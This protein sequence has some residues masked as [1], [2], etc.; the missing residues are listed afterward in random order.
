MRILL[1]GL[2]LLVTVA[3][4]AQ[5]T[6]EYTV[7][8]KIIGVEDGLSSRE[9]FCGLMDD[10]G[11]LWLGTR[12][13]LNRYDGK[14]FKVFNKQN[15][16][17][18]NKVINVAKTGKNNLLISYGDDGFDRKVCYFEVF[19]TKTF[20]TKQL[21]EIIPNMPFSV[22]DIIWITNGGTDDVNVLVARPY[23][24]YQLTSKGLRIRFDLTKW[25]ENKVSRDTGTNP[26]YKRTGY[27]SV[28]RNGYAALGLTSDPIYFVTPENIF[29]T[30]A[31]AMM[32]YIN[33]KNDFTY[34]FNGEFHQLSPDGTDRKIARYLPE[35]TI[36][37]THLVGL[38]YPEHRDYA[39]LNTVDS[40]LMLWENDQTKELI[41][42]S[43]WASY[44]TPTINQCFSDQLGND[45]LCTS[46]GL[47]RIRISKNKFIHH[48]TGEQ[49]K[50]IDKNQARGIF[51]DETGNV[52]AGIWSAFCKNKSIVF[53]GNDIFY[54]VV[55]CDKTF[56]VSG[57]SLYTLNE[58]TEKASMKDLGVYQEEMWHLYQFNTN[59]L[60]IGCRYSIRK[61]DITTNRQKE[62][63]YATTQIP[64]VSS[65]Y[66]II[67][68]TRNEML[69]LAESGIYKLNSIGDTITEY[70]G[71][72]TAVSSAIVHPLACA[73]LYD[74]YQDKEGIFWIATNG[75][76][77]YR[78]DR[79][80]N[81][82]THFDNA[83]GFSS[84]TLY[85]IEGDN[86][87]NL[88]ISSDYGLACLNTKSF[89]VRTYTT[90]D[91]I[92]NNEFNR[93]SSY[94]AA[95]GTLYFGGMNGV[96]SLNP[97]DFIYDSMAL[98]APFVVTNFS[99]YDGGAKLL[100]NRTDDLIAKK[101]IVLQPADNFFDL[102][103]QLLDYGDEV[104]KY[105]YKIDGVASDWNY[106]SDNTIRISRLPYGNYTLHIKAQNIAGSWNANELNI[107]VKVLKPFYLKTWFIIS[108]IALGLLLIA[109]FIL[110]RISKIKKDKQILE[111]TINERTQQLK[112]A[113][114][115][116]DILLKEIHHRVKNNLAVI[117]GILDLQQRQVKNELLT[118]F[119]K[120]AKT[121]IASMALVHKNLYEDNSDGNSLLQ[122][123][124]ESLFNTV[125]VSYKPKGKKVDHKISCG[126]LKLNIDTL[127]P[128]ALIV[129]ELLTNSFKYAFGMKEEGLISITIERNEKYFLL[130][131]ADNGK[132][133]AANYDPTENKSLGT[134]LIN[135]LTEQLEGKVIVEN[136]PDVGLI[137]YINFTAINEQY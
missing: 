15:G 85:R 70:W 26:Y 36:D 98:D 72:E 83:Y 84:N 52:Y 6:H 42:A 67:K 20:E 95:N 109:S 133:L 22:E 97:A 108:A 115:Q 39:Y 3:L 50:S 104:H 57:M 88:W 63:A 123:Y 87:G 130:T 111:Q 29:K 31:G 62:V 76:G 47:W 35:S 120:D 107:R 101:E 112:K 125:A 64:K 25:D 131:Y 132:G 68:T 137:Y 58:I 46:A 114:E 134:R 17:K 56:Y 43:T 59:E 32:G 110:W 80:K 60:L 10:D 78:W 30:Q 89:T 102:Q 54:S 53:A 21:K 7:S 90:K 37:R 66:R 128:L 86:Y 77:L 13:G 23:R 116:K 124:F 82:L 44:G 91:G 73:N 38:H 127:I 4:F 126:D 51:A 92:S 33:N 117:S 94:K 5:N 75:A 103:F 45:W 129:N 74:L 40:G 100:I 19:N 93:C 41:N 2:A 49:I 135:R 71:N 61:Y 96:N 81:E 105:A 8:K 55:K 14:N 24:Y 121:R 27:Y 99:Q 69:A 1:F 113:L 65:V 79:D 16:L 11:F 136:K 122:L 9:V 18:Y 28:Y 119:V 118:A 34:I 48:F 106:T 12:N